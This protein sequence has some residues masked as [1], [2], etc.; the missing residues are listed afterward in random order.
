MIISLQRQRSGL[1][2]A[3]TT[4]QYAPLPGL[5]VL[6]LDMQGPEAEEAGDNLSCHAVDSSQ[7]LISHK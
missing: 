5:E 4:Q 6:R 2:T 3:I 1:T 7:F